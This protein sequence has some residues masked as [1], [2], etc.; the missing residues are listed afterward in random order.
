M[1]IPFIAWVFQGIPESIGTAAVVISLSFHK[2]H[3]RLII[4]IGLI[5][6]AVMYS[7]RLLA[8]TFGVHTVI[9]IISLSLLSAWIA[10][11]ELRRAI[12]YANIAMM[13]LAVTEFLFVYFIISLGL[14]SYNAIFDDLLT[15]ILVGTPQ[16]VVLFLA[17]ILYSRK[18]LDQKNMVNKEG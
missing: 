3:W 1:E 14:C 17:A 6:A 10:K 2:L 9:L 5:Q 12:I 13:A 15:R 8:L 4:I 11:I 7:V 16:V 18:M